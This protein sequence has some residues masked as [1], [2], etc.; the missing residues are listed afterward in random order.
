MSNPPSSDNKWTKVMSILH[1][2][3][4]QAV[5]TPLLSKKYDATQQIIERYELPIFVCGYSVAFS[6]IYVYRG[7]EADWAIM[8]LKDDPSYKKTGRLIAPK[9]IVRDLDRFAKVGLGF[10]EYYIAH[11]IPGRRLAAG[12]QFPYDLIMPPPPRKEMGE[13]IAERIGRG[14]LR[15]GLNTL[16]GVATLGLRVTIGAAAI[17]A[18]GAA[19]AAA[20]LPSATLV[21]PILFGIHIDP[22]VKHNRQPIGLWYYLAQWYW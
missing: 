1:P 13:D 12:D 6:G 9:H 3:A 2:P 7:D 15:L 22:E 11:E 18:T 17:G 4:G 10:D 14:A 16:V 20:A 8:N 21:D 19:L 5:L